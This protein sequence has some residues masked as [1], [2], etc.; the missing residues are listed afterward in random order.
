MDNK[1]KLSFDDK[2]DRG[3]DWALV[4]C[5]GVSA[6]AFLVSWNFLGGFWAI[7]ASLCKLEAMEAKEGWSSCL[8]DMAEIVMRRKCPTAMDPENDSGGGSA[9]DHAE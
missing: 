3:L 2:L 6:A 8:R 4:A 5:A 7:L 9:E 1:E